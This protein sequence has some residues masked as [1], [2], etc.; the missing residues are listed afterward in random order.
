[1]RLDKLTTKSQEA[2]QEA[3]RIAQE[4]SH[5]EVDG[6]HL[7]L[8]LI[9]QSESLIP[10]LLDKIGV[11]PA[12]LKRDVEQ[13]L[14]RRHKVQGAS[15]AYAGAAVGVP[16]TVVMPAA[17]N[18]TKVAATRGYGAE[19]VLEGAHFGEVYAAMERIRDERALAGMTVDEAFPRELIAHE[20]K[21]GQCAHDRVDHR[22]DRRSPQGQLQGRPGHRQAHLAPQAGQPLAQA[23]LDPLDE[24]RPALLEQSLT[25]FPRNAKSETVEGSGTTA[26]SANTNWRSLSGEI[27]RVF[28][29][30]SFDRMRSVARMMG[31][32]E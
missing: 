3:Q 1:M 11:P 6:E 10:E 32:S 4:N 16:V 14:A 7:L 20:D 21:G 15:D 8:A 9:G 24:R 30:D 25:L 27:D 17:A 31:R 12:K 22:H 19:V 2:L 18:P 23:V 26:Q 29:S 5:Q 13:E 28:A